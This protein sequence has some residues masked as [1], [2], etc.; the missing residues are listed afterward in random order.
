[1]YF[2]PKIYPITD[3]RI[4]GLSHAEQIKRLIAGGAQIIQLREKHASPREFYA[5]ALAASAVAKAH[6]V[7][8]I[9][10]DRVDIAIAVQAA[11]VHLGQDDMPPTEARAIL[12]DK[13]I[14]GF[15][16]HT[17]EQA[18]AAATM[19][20]DYIAFG[21]VFPTQTKD[22]P[23]DVVGLDILRVARKAVGDRPLV[24]IGGIDDSNLLSVLAAG[25][26]TAAMIGS[27]LS[28]PLQI[29]DRMLKL[30]ALAK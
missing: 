24:A 5:A 25:A 3:Q 22:A 15:S 7:P 16:T 8:M 11:G 1:M 21:P 20:V 26:D 17:I 30:I 14:I 12:G 19:P 28:D 4:S 2:L 13:A 6:D 23:D 27:L 18:A 29:T 9:I 10:N